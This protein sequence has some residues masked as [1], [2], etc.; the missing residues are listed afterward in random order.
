MYTVI[1]VLNM[2]IEKT[3]LKELTKSINNAFKNE[4]GT[5]RN[6]HNG[7]PYHFKFAANEQNIE[8][9]KSGFE[10][11]SGNMTLLKNA[12]I[13]KWLDEDNA[14]ADDYKVYI[15]LKDNTSKE[16]LNKI[17]AAAMEKFDNR[18]GRP[19]LIIGESLYEFEFFCHE[20]LHCALQ[21]GAIE[22]FEDAL[23][24]ECVEKFAWV[25]ND[26]FESGDMIIDFSIPVK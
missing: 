18:I 12:I 9:L 16:N 20:D 13:F 19:E 17:F 23:F 24:R 25:E 2:H 8:C 1:I 11:L 4:C 21:L 10:T 5:L 3:L 15:K 7:S 14:D 22:L 26:Y 6:R